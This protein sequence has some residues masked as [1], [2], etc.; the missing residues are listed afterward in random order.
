MKLDERGNLDRCRVDFTPV[1]D[2]AKE[3]AKEIKLV[4]NDVL[5][6]LGTLVD[7][8]T[9]PHVRRLLAIAMSE[10]EG[11]CMWAVKG[12]TAEGFAHGATQQ[13]GTPTVD[14]SSQQ[15]P[16]VGGTQQ[17]QRP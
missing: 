17:P 5:M 11:A 9:D 16:N 8:Q 6:S 7:V 14:P 15:G 2:A 10:Y 13:A 3:L 1:S 4:T 12:M